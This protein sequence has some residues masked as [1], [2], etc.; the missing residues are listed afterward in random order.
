VVLAQGSFYLLEQMVVIL[1]EE[2][3]V[4]WLPAILEKILFLRLLLEGEFV[5]AVERGGMGEF[6]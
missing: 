1:A 6:A 5:V 2:H 4:G 3:S